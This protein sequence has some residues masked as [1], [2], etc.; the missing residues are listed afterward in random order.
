[1]IE[2]PIIA[3]QFGFTKAYYTDDGCLLVYLEKNNKQVY[4]K[5][6]DVSRFI[7]VINRVEPPLVSDLMLNILTEKLLK[8]KEEMERELNNI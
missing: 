3:E 6:E 7:E 5:I 4:R 1:M 8:A 2:I